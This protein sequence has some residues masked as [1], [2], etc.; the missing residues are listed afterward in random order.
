M[1]TLNGRGFIPTSTEISLL[2]YIENSTVA[3][4]LLSTQEQN[5]GLER[6]GDGPLSS[7]K[8]C[9]ENTDALQQKSLPLFTGRHLLCI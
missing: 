6:V 7:D 4:I 8:V 5:F 3:Q 9:R 2:R 1:V